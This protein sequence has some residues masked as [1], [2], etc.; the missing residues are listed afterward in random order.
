[1]KRVFFS[2]FLFSLALLLFLEAL[3]V[4]SAF[5]EASNPPPTD[6][7]FPFMNIGPLFQQKAGDLGANNFFIHE[8]NRW[9]DEAPLLRTKIGVRPG[10]DS[11]VVIAFCDDPGN[12]E[13]DGWKLLS[14]SGSRNASLI[15]SCD[16]SSC[17][18]VGVVPV[19]RFGETTTDTE[20]DTPAVGCKAGVRAAGG[21]SQ[22]TVVAHCICDDH[23]DLCR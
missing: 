10:P 22:P 16:E 6:T 2:S 19:N 4:R 7:I 18:F 21:V 17:K 8:A 14:C 23:T 3:T 20:G 15:D 1:M 12:P 5:R 13:D 11:P 9:A